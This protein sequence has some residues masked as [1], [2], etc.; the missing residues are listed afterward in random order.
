MPV[1]CPSG[2][3][4][5]HLPRQDVL[6]RLE[7]VHAFRQVPAKKDSSTR[8]GRKIVISIPCKPAMHSYSTGTC[9]TLGIMDGSPSTTVITCSTA[10]IST[11]TVIQKADSD[12]NS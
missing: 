5:Q 11:S 4:S 8:D 12:M 2:P 7:F 3:P 6:E 1:R 9:K 10:T